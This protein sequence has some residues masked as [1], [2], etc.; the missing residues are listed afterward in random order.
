MKRDS[1]PCVEEFKEVDMSTRFAVATA[2]GVRLIEIDS[3]QMRQIHVGLM[4]LRITSIINVNGVL[5]AGTLEGIYRSMDGGK[6]WLLSSIGLRERY[7]RSLSAIPSQ[8]G[9]ILAGTEPAT[10][11]ISHDTGLSWRECREIA[12]LRNEKGWFLPY[13]EAHGCVRGFAFHDFRSYAAAEVGGVLRSDNEGETWRLVPGCTGDPVARIPPSYI[14]TDV[15]SIETHHS[16]QGLLFAATGGGFYRSENGGG[17][18]QHVNQ[19]YCRALWVDP[20]DPNHII[21]GSADAVDTNGRI[22]ETINGGNSW[23][24]STG[25]LPARWPGHMVD[26]FY[27]HDGDLYGILTNGSIITSRIGKFDWAP[28]FPELTHVTGIVAIS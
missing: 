7:V 6:R 26:R 27:I 11:H 14:H 12:A 5:L 20:H 13:S 25:S 1:P 23:R 4:G 21:L 16:T 8:S 17:S 22:E 18:W 15:H 9:H 3:G 2:Q 19:C 10:I 28:V 24:P